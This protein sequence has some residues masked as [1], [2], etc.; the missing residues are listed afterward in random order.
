MLFVLQSCIFAEKSHL[1]SYSFFCFGRSFLIFV[2]SLKEGVKLLPVKTGAARFLPRGRESPVRIQLVSCYINSPYRTISFAS[3]REK[4]KLRLARLSREISIFQTILRL[5][6]KK[7][8]EASKSKPKTKL[9]IHIITS[10]C[11][12]IFYNKFFLW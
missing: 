4:E 11:K 3:R 1:A 12:L 5:P 9:K 2:K 7:A 8:R 6:R 10:T